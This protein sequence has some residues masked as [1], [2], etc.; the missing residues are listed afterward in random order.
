MNLPIIKFHE[1]NVWK[2]KLSHYESRLLLESGS[3]NLISFAIIE[4]P[5]VAIGILY[6]EDSVYPKV[7]YLKNLDECFIGV[8]NRLIIVN[9]VKKK[10]ISKIDLQSFF[11][12]VLEVANKGIIVV[13]EI[14]IGLYESTG[15]RIWFTPTDLI[16]NYLVE[17]D[18]I[19]VTTDSGKI[20]LSIST[21]KI[22]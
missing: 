14:G 13:E 18:N 9:I 19:I 6:E 2:N 1:K 3:E 10:V 21:G 4:T 17:N 15:G 12:D 22:L 11:M 7:K 20:M 8:D 5:Y 16:E